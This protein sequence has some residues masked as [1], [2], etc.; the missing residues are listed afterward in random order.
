MLISDHEDFFLQKGVCEK[1]DYQRLRSAGFVYSAVQPNTQ[2]LYRCYSEAEH[3]HFAS[4]VEDCNNMGK[5]E[6]LLG[7]DLK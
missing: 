2:P 5:R 4:N 6:A 7:Y 1:N 3:S